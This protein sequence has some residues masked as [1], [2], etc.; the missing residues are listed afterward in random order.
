VP[1]AKPAT[2]GNPPR[3]KTKPVRSRPSIGAEIEFDPKAQIKQVKKPSKVGATKALAL[4]ADSAAL[5]RLWAIVEAR[6]AADP[7]I[8]HSARLLGRGRQQVAT[9]QSNGA[10]KRLIESVELGTTKIP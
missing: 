2:A 1:K 3:K 9:G 10:L 4:A 7:V 6:K 5:N 8:S